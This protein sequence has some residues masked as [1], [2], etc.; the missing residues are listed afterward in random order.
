MNKT[1]NFWWK[2]LPGVAKHAS[3][4]F[5]YENIDNDPEKFWH[6]LSAL[7]DQLRMRIATRLVEING[8]FAALTWLVLSECDEDAGAPLHMPFKWEYTNEPKTKILANL[9]QDFRYP[10]E[11]ELTEQQRDIKRTVFHSQIKD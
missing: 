11:N 10:P 1:A 9:H 5:E 4:V 2:R 8:T 3:R 7:P 6:M